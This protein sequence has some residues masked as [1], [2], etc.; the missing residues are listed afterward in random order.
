MTYSNML[1][2]C[3]SLP[4]YEPA[5]EKKKRKAEEREKADT[6]KESDKNYKSALKEIIKN[7]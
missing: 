6:I 2:Y 1:L 5:E 7:S 3:A 4:S